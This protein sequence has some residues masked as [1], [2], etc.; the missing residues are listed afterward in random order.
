MPLHVDEL[1][2][3]PNFKRL[4]WRYLSRKMEKRARENTTFHFIVLC[5]CS[6]V[7]GFS[8]TIWSFS[9]TSGQKMARTIIAVSLSKWDNPLFAHL[10]FSQQ[11]QR[12]TDVWSQSFHLYNNFCIYLSCC[13]R[14]T[15]TN[16]WLLSFFNSNW[17]WKIVN[18]INTFYAAHVF[19]IFSAH[20]KCVSSLKVQQIWISCAL[21]IAQ[22]GVL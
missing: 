19:A 18:E 6:F 12:R 11:S 3:K 20:S 7:S 2:N 21:H 22:W 17:S 15:E 4:I 5:H 1:C 9:G 8:P 14:L 16:H 13:Y 10:L